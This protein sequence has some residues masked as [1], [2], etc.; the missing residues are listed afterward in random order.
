MSRIRSRDTTVSIDSQ[1]VIHTTQAIRGAGQF[2]GFQCY[3]SPFDHSESYGFTASSFGSKVGVVET[4]TDVA[5][6][7]GTYNPVTHVKTEWDCPFISIG[8]EGRLY[9]FLSELRGVTAGNL[10]CGPARASWGSTAFPATWD[11]D[12]NAVVRATANMQFGVQDAQFDLPTFLGEL[13]DYRDVFGSVLGRI[14][15]HRSGNGTFTNVKEAKRLLQRVSHMSLKDALTVI[16]KSDL[17]VQF[18]VNPLMNDLNAMQKTYA[19]VQNQYRRLSSTLPT[20]VRGS[21]HDE[22][23]DSNSFSDDSHPWRSDREYRRDIT[24]WAMIRFRPADAQYSLLPR[25]VAQDALNFD[26]P[27]SVWWEITPFSWLLDYV[28]GV[29][30]WLEG[31]A[32]QIVEVPYDILDQGYSVKRLASCVATTFFDEGPYTSDWTNYSIAN[33]TVKGRVISS[34]YTRVKDTLPIGELPTLA[35]K[36]PNFRQVRNVIDLFW[37]LS[38]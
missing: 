36:L 31:F 9:P 34:S 7:R 17:F 25:H 22:G 38:Q 3:P 12:A 23:S 35:A 27:I 20:R 19:H 4:M 29:G 2:L 26:K 11:S 24:T 8:Y 6:G 14:K 5:K 28:F 1:P 15:L 30:D 21:V 16:A 32:G 10:S 37:I 33:N 18:A 13:R